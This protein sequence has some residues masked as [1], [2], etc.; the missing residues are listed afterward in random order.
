MDH[1]KLFAFLLFK[2]LFLRPQ[3]VHPS[4]KFCGGGQ[5]EGE[6]HDTMRRGPAQQRPRGRADLKDRRSLERASVFRGHLD[7]HRAGQRRD[8][9]H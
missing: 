1:L 4:S 7:F 5:I 6:F 9:F 3:A 8:G 2:F